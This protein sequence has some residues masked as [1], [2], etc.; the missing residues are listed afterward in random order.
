MEEHRQPTEEPSGNDQHDKVVTLLE[1]IHDQLDRSHR[2]AR[3]QDFS[4]LRLFGALLQLLAVIAALWGFAALLDGRD[5]TSAARL[6][7]ACFFQLACLAAV[8]I[9]RLP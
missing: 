2:Q 6:L 7:L 4:V 9:D 5:L 8:A 1:K 3:Q